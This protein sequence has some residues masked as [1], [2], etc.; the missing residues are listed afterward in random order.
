MPGSEGVLE[1]VY[2][3]GKEVGWTLVYEKA[4]SLYPP[5]GFRPMDG[6]VHTYKTFSVRD[7]RGV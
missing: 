1:D 2:R 4:I 6:S 7:A 5:R 3:F